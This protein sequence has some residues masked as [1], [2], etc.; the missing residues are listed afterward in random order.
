MVWRVYSPRSYS[1]V[2]EVGLFV[3]GAEP[4]SCLSPQHG[5]SPENAL[6]T[7]VGLIYF[8]GALLIGEDLHPLYRGSG[9]EIVAVVG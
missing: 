6:H 9:D 1:L 5:G 7:D 2:V 8:W 3:L 4:I